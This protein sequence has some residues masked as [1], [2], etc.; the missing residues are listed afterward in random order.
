LVTYYFGKIS[1]DHESYMRA[2]LGDAGGNRYP[3]FSDAPLGGFADLAHDLQTHATAFLNGDFTEFARCIS[4]A[5][6]WK[7][8]PGFA[9]L[10]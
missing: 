8:I 5:K 9:R 4:A 10:P 6:E 1:P 2:S 3:G 7:K